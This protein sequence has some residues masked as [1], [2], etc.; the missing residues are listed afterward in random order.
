[1][2]IILVECICK[3]F[4]LI[5][6]ENLFIDSYFIIWF[7]FSNS[8]FSDILLTNFIRFDSLNLFAKDRNTEIVTLLV[9]EDV[10]KVYQLRNW[11]V[12][13]ER[14]TITKLTVVQSMI[15]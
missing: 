3:L 4:C 7:C 10:K 12:N 8:H 1:M 15:L 13:N 9:K 2:Y 6:E 11:R 14:G 5:N